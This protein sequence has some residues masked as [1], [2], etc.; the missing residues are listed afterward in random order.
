MS[1]KHGL[2][3][4]LSGQEWSGYDLEKLFRSSIGFFWNAK[5]S[6]VYRDLHTME[7]AGWVV[8]RDVIQAGRPNKKVF[9]IT[10]AG[11]EELENWLT[12][13]SIEND[14]EIRVGILMRMFFAAKRPKEETIALLERFRAAC[15]KAK[16]ALGGISEKIEAC[17]TESME[18]LYTKTTLSY[19]GR[20]YQMQ[21][22]WC[23]ETL[24][25]LRG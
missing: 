19:G 13:Y 5:I 9:S 10:D 8:A 7:D 22:D 11:R 1:L 23:D 24:K 25:I 2:L 20:Y 6:Q 18:I 14:F 15:Y 16:A 4:F 3:G 17:G 12:D 21:I